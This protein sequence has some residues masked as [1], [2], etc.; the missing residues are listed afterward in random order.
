MSNDSPRKRR[1][2][3]DHVAEDLDHADKDADHG[4][5]SAGRAAEES[6]RAGG[7]SGGAERAALRNGA[8]RAAAPKRVLVIADEWF[9][10]RGGLSSL[11]R[12]LCAALAA[13]GAEVHCLVPGASAEERADAAAS[14]VRLLEARRSPGTSERE[15]LMRRPPLPPGTEPDAVIG[16]GRVTGPIA[17]AVTEDHYPRAA[18][19]HLVHMAPDE[20]EW[21]KLDGGNDAGLRADTRSRIELDLARDATAAVPV[22]P[23]LHGWLARDLP[24]GRDGHRARLIQLDPGFDMAGPPERG[25]RAGRPL[26]MIMGR[27]DDVRLKGVD[28]AA[29]AIGRARG[30]YAGAADWELLVRGT[31]AGTEQALR[32]QVLGW[33][34]DPSASVT[35]RPYSAETAAIQE[36]L[37]RASLL[38]MPSLVEGYGLVGHEAIVNGTP[39]LISANSGLAEQVAKVA[40]DHAGALVVPVRH[41]VEEDVP[42]WGHR[43]AAVMGDREAAFAR[44]ARARRALAEKAS[45][46]MAV[47]RLLTVL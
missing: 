9:P 28:L 24:A 2:N 38:L 37:D 36:D 45:W 41:R 22:G 3:I 30:L 15:A 25:I 11:N 39:A 27:M 12:H 44:A 8:R 7:D 26:V 4:D 31:P 33:I 5:G 10:A 40:P 23:R 17:N 13:A 29:R 16:H 14:G 1:W 32:T 35:V 19:F 21:Y 34:G 43:I 18:R 46:A 20:I 42:A 6:A 47:D